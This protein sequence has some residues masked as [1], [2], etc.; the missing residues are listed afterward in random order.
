MGFMHTKRAFYPLAV[1][2]FSVPVFADVTYWLDSSAYNHAEVK[3]AI[4]EAVPIYNKYGSF[5][6]HLAVYYNSGVPTAQANY[7]GVITF[8]GSRN[9]RVALHEMGHTVG[10]GTYWGSPSYSSLMAGGVWQGY[11]GRKLA[12]EMGSAYADGLHGDGDHIWPWGLNY[13]SEDGFMERVRHVRIMAAVRCDMGIMAYNREAGHQIVPIGETAVFG[14][15][16]PIAATYQ[17]YKDGVALSNGG[18]ISGA[19]RCT[20]QIANVDL[21]DEGVYFCAAVGAGETLNSRGRRLI[22]EKQVGQWNFDG[23]ANDS[24]GS[25][26]GSVS[27]AAV[28]TTGVIDQAIVLNG[29]NYVSLPAGVADAQDMTAAAWVYWAGGNQWQ[30]IFDFGTS[31]SQNLFLT[32]RSG[33]NTLRFAIKDGGTEQQ[34]DAPQL[35][36]GQW[37]HLAVTLRNDT[38]TLY[39]NGKPAASNNAV[40]IDPADF[41]P[42]LNYIGKSQWPDPLFNG[43]IDD[44]RLYNYA[45]T[46]SEIWSLWGQNANVPP[47]FAC[48]VLL[49]PEG[50]SGTAYTGPTLVNYASDYDGG[51]LTF[52][53]ISGPAWLNV[54]SNGT[55]SG[56]PGPADRGENTAAVRVADPSGATDDATISITVLG[57]PD[58]HYGFEANAQDSAGSSHGSVTGAPVYTAGIIGRAVDLDGTDDYV[59]LP[60]GI[61]ETQDF[62]IAAWINWDGGAQW[63]R[64]FDFGSNTT[65]YMFLTPKSGSNTLRFAI[66]CSGGG[67]REEILETAALTVGQWTHVAVTLSGDSGKLYVNGQ[68]ADFNAAM[69]IDPSD[70]NP[71]NNYIG[72]SQWPDPLFNGRIDDFRIYT[73][74]LSD[75]EIRELSLPPSFL[76]ETITNVDGTELYAYSGQSLAAFVDAPGGTDTL[77]FSKVS[78]P[79]WLVVAPDGTLSG[80]PSD[81]DK[82]TNVF[83]VSVANSAGLFNTAA[84]TVF[85]ADT[86]SGTQGL[87][88]LLGLACQWL[89]SDCTDIPACGGADLDADGKADL[90]D[91][92]AM[93]YNWF[94][95]ESLQLFLRF[96][97]GSGDAAR[98]D[99]IY[100]RDGLLV[101][102]PTWSFD[103][104]GV[105][106]FDGTDDYIQ[107]AGYK[108]VTGSASRTCCA[109]IKTGVSP[110]NAVIMDWGTAAVGGQ[111]LFGIFANGQL[112][113]YSQGPYIAAS[114][115][116]ND[117]QWH[118]VAAVLDGDHAFEL[119]DI[120]LYVDGV[121]QP[122]TAAGSA[123]ID[124]GVRGDVT[125]GALNNAGAAAAVYKGLMDDVRIYNRALTEPE[126]QE[127]AA[128]HP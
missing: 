44:F 5:N 43:R 69:T 119:N 13:D 18:D 125:I 88:D 46:G 114:Q 50:S 39:V 58:A 35:P 96:D 7:D 118:H 3:A 34:V 28:Y 121:P 19:D 26:P 112:G 17:W 16:S 73:Y 105:M 68:L 64:I 66:T 47:A 62:T 124:T 12:I 76:Q 55:L 78:G 10:V 104:S 113:V 60:A 45:L 40:T 53:K 36:V 100:R 59:T 98:D 27:G 21:G 11:Y 8:G 122:V 25:H 41:A 1:L 33:G 111:W 128:S 86:F 110:V 94:G 14:V 89:A 84:M 82:G 99:S 92:S 61:A 9:T 107:I 54:A 106:E 75:A 30:R 115:T 91:F 48:D 74:A 120:R 6:K 123:A 81:K 56:T 71:S 108:G 51:M 24:V 42:N 4:E 65:Q 77:I 20:L 29:T 101:N 80:I 2:L 102:G 52:S 93:A 90:S 126:I 63:Q 72:K 85:V 70:F 32:P 109:W 79:E 31:T 23:N 57:P 95:D 103:N 87:S 116:V 97:D 37:V 117:S 127:L 67:T 49:L 15:S 83:T 22:I 38:A